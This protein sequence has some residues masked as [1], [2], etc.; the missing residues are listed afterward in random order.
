MKNEIILL[1]IYVKKLY[2][3]KNESFMFL[4]IKLYVYI[5]F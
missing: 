5:F 2:Y 3:I 4:E 1:F